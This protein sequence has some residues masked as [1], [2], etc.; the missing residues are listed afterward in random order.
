VTVI[1]DDAGE[2]D[3]TLL[4]T[5]SGD[6]EA[7]KRIPYDGVR[8]Y[9]TRTRG[10]STGSRTQSQYGLSVD[11]VIDR[12]LSQSGANRDRPTV[13]E[14]V[15]R[16][17]REAYDT[18]AQQADTVAVG[19]DT[20][21]VSV[22]VHISRELWATITAEARHRYEHDPEASAGDAYWDAVFEHI[23]TVPNIIVEDEVK[24]PEDIADLEVSS[25]A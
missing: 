19:S 2:D 22:D 25:D 5:E 12:Y 18:I 9:T 11:A 20:N 3:Y 23:E 15:A 24:G 10:L 14:D 17:L 21:A 6:V 16:A 8:Y 7:R 4:V 13:A 1:I